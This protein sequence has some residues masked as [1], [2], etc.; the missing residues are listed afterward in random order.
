MKKQLFCCLIFFSFLFSCQEK[1]IVLESLYISNFYVDIPRLYN[2]PYVVHNAIIKVETDE[3][4]DLSEY[5][6][7]LG[8]TN[9][10]PVAKLVLP[11]ISDGVLTVEDVSGANYLEVEIADNGITNITVWNNNLLIY[12]AEGV[13]D[14]HQYDSFSTYSFLSGNQKIYKCLSYDN[15]ICVC[16][17]YTDYMHECDSFVVNELIYH[18]EDYKPYLS[19]TQH[20]YYTYSVTHYYKDDILEPWELEDGSVY[21]KQKTKLQYKGRNGER[22]SQKDLYYLLAEDYSIYESDFCDQ[23][24]KTWYMALKNNAEGIFFMSETPDLNY[25]WRGA[26]FRFYFGYWD[27][28][29]KNSR[30]SIEPIYESDLQTLAW[31][32]DVEVDD[33]SEMSFSSPSALE[34]L[35]LSGEIHFNKMH[36]TVEPWL[37]ELFDGYIKEEK[38]LY[39]ERDRYL[40]PH[41]Y[42]KDKKEILCPQCNGLGKFYDSGTWYRCISCMGSGTQTIYI[43]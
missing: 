40:N 15:T 24:G 21:R 36:I 43:D 37:K 29:K 27:R 3:P 19:D 10:L 38:D 12:E 26:A 14:E 42:A 39:Y 17:R 41:K 23:D 33:L 35:G 2:L 22:L 5:Y 6:K 13:F 11:K 25:V 18:D 16:D 1:S 7:E 28:D 34:N 4:F 30:I 8:A 31:D 20:G 9:K 32:Y